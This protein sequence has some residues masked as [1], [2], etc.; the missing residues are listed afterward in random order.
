VSLVGQ[1]TIERDL[2][3]WGVRRQHQALRVLHTSSRDV[4]ERGA[5]EA[6]TEGA[7]EMAW[8]QAHDS[9]QLAASDRHIEI[10]LDVRCDFA[11]LPWS[12]SAFR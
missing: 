1:A 9:R 2:A 11:D 12:Q 7:T 4:L 5:S 8:A 6:V 10:R 3:Q